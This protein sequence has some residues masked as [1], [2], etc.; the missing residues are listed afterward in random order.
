MPSYL[1]Y[2]ALWVLAVP[3]F[4]QGVDGSW[5]PAEA[6]EDGIEFVWDGVADAKGLCGS[7]CGWLLLFDPLRPQGQTT[8]SREVS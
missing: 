6:P 7:P 3:R 5:L 8:I 4:W 2:A 1:G